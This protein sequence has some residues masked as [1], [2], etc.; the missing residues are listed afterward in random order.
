MA[1]GGTAI[2]AVAATP[3]TAPIPAKPAE[4]VT[5][6]ECLASFV[7]TEPGPFTEAASFRRYVAGSEANMAVGLARLG[8]RVA[9][10]GCVG[11]DGF[12]TAIV[13]K[14][15]G[16]G[17]DVG[18][19][20][21]VD[22]ARTGVMFRERRGAGP[23]EVIYHRSGSAGSMFGPADVSTA[24]DAG[25]LSGARRLHCSGI[26]P[27]ISTSARAATIL[28]IDMAAAAGLE[29]SLDLNLRRRLWTDE[30]AAAVLRPLVSRCDV[31]FA[32][33]DE[34]AVVAGLA[35]DSDPRSVAEALIALG[36]RRAVLKLG[37]HGAASLSAA[38]EWVSA[39]AFPVVV[40]DPVGAG[41]AFC[42]GYLAGLL[43]GLDEMSALRLGNACGA[44]VAAAE[45]DLTGAPTRLEAERMVGPGGGAEQSIR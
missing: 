9:Y 6:G 18:H 17:I 1:D 45:G 42:A 35:P 43:E 14:L 3:A 8:H 22:G 38:G 36:A 23:T 21:V 34:A 16:E 26:T 28:A 12:G 40:V 44:S 11:D 15:R 27:A 37:A 5:F 33:L 20:R 13:R 25:A 7:G 29:I 41:D 2:P 39:P 10:L 32:S 24:V 31:V 30:E 19:L 4:V